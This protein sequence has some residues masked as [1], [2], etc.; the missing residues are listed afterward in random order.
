M[1]SVQKKKKKQPKPLTS[2]CSGSIK[3][4]LVYAWLDRF[5]SCLS[6]PLFVPVSFLSEIGTSFSQNIWLLVF[7]P[8][9]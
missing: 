5:I 8:V 6:H 2:G 9:F 3:A 1:P 4:D 7:I